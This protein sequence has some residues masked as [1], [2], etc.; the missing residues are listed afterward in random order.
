MNH[1]ELPTPELLDSGHVNLS[2]SAEEVEQKKNV[3]LHVFEDLGIEIFDVKETVGPSSIFYEL[4]LPIVNDW[5]KA[6]KKYSK[7][8]LY[9]DGCRADITVHD[10][11]EQVITVEV[12]RKEKESFSI[13]SAIES[14]AFQE[15]DAILPVV[16]GK[17]NMNE[18]LVTDLVKCPHL[19]IAGDKDN[20]QK[21]LLD[22][23]MLSLL[24]KKK[25]D[26]LKFVF[27][28][29]PEVISDCYQKIQECFCAKLPGV[30][31]SVITNCDTAIRT[32]DALCEE[33]DKRYDILYKSKMRSIEEYNRK[34]QNQELKFPVYPLPYIVVFIEEFGDLMLIYGK[35]FELSLCRLAQLSR[36]V[37]IH[38]VMASI[39]TDIITGTIKANFPARVAFPVCS[40]VASKV[41][42]DSKEAK[43]LTDYGDM[44]CRVKGI[45]ERARI[46][47][48]EH[49]EIEKVADYIYQ[50]GTYEPY[51]LPEPTMI[52]EEG[53]EKD[54]ELFDEATEII[55]RNLWK[56]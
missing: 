29:K 3:I 14:K 51:L 26:E 32:L 48:V 16:L 5:E 34:I 7:I 43:K 22:T 20:G 23:I 12:S 41:V 54:D 21:T 17:T 52:E 45:L 31:R 39:R 40:T 11:R 38:V 50:Q 25:P 28:A 13:R 1:Y 44:F 46:F 4:S 49:R 47:S 36:A 35:R 2:V 56:K 18:I 33:M 24:Y 42:I 37:G 19:L 8:F 53:E 15:G 10:P 30:Y 27:I 6:K 55:M 9:I